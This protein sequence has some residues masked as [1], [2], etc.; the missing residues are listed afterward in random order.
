MGSGLGLRVTTGGWGFGFGSELRTGS[1][2]EV[3][4]LGWNLGFQSRVGTRIQVRRVLVWVEGSEEPWWNLNSDV[5][6]LGRFRTLLLLGRRRLPPAGRHRQRRLALQPQ[7][8][9]PGPCGR[10]PSVGGAY[11]LPALHAELLPGILRPPGG[12]SDQLPLAV[13][14]QERS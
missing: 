6:S 7:E 9:L 14:L 3:R 2:V 11:R 4:V 13:R 5:P 10:P 1:E 8:L 12:A